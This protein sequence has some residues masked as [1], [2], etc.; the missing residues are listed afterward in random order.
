MILHLT[1]MVDIIVSRW[2]WLEIQQRMKP[3]VL[4]TNQQ[5]NN[6]WKYLDIN[7]SLAMAHWSRAST[8]NNWIREI[9]DSVRP[10]GGSSNVR[11]S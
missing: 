3:D 7:Q 8:Q 9:C 1:H 4:Q 6:A 10:C 2:V 5:I 11:V